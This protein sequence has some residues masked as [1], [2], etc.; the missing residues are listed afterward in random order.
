MRLEPVLEL[1]DFPADDRGAAYNDRVAVWMAR[2]AQ[3][4]YE[5]P[6]TIST[7]LQQNGFT[8]VCFFYGDSTSCYLAEHASDFAVLAFRGTQA[9]DFKDVWTDLSVIKRPMPE[10][11]APPAVNGNKE[12]AGAVHGG[13][14]SAL[15]E[16]CRVHVVPTADTSIEIQS[17][18]KSEIRDAVSAARDRGSRLY[19]TGHS[20]GGA[21]A[22][23]AAYRLQREF[24]VTAV[25]TIGSPRVAS[26]T[27]AKRNPLDGQPSAQP[28]SNHPAPNYYRIVHQQDIV[29]HIP[30]IGYQHVGREHHLVSKQG[31]P[32][33][34]NGHLATG[35]FSKTVTL[36]GF[37]VILLSFLLA[38]EIKNPG[39]F[40]QSHLMDK[41]ETVQPSAGTPHLRDAQAHIT[42]VRDPDPGPIDKLIE[43]LAPESHAVHIKTKFKVPRKQGVLVIKEDSVLLPYLEKHGYQ[44]TQG[45]Q[46]ILFEYDAD[47][48]PELLVFHKDLQPDHSVTPALIRRLNSMVYHWKLQWGGA[49]PKYWLDNLVLSWLQLVFFFI[50]LWILLSIKRLVSKTPLT[51]Q[52]VRVGLGRQLL[53]FAC[54]C[55]TNPLIELARFLP[56]YPNLWLN[57]LI[58]A[59]FLVVLLFGVVLLLKLLPTWISNP[60]LSLVFYQAIQDHSAGT[61]VEKLFQI[62]VPSSGDADG[63]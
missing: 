28:P 14:L 6:T 35:T 25:Y 10:Y 1:P 9:A 12:P 2:C 42:L 29:T 30:L 37:T 43:D 62:A 11:A 40:L 55:F 51:P 49:I 63:A 26:K 61:Y 31:R 34:H 48:N 53:F 5:N 4:C 39:L 41:I 16:V 47:T 8:R 45:R 38:S 44:P 17:Y 58:F 24:A 54:I 36:W 20:L 13:F 60:I 32:E 27:F 33:V 59:A 23:L 52:L 56:Q 3:L 18:G 15:N 21:L 57:N 46:E 7:Y 19:I 22:T 50:P